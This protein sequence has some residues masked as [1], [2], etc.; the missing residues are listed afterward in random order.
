MLLVTLGRE[1][2][3]Y[4]YQNRKRGQ[5][6]RLLRYIIITYCYELLPWVGLRYLVTF[7]NSR[8]LIYRLSLQTY[9]KLFNIV[10]VFNMFLGLQGG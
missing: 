10:T 4:V 8:N 3:S 7:I 2:G 6:L 5:S 1:A 9:I